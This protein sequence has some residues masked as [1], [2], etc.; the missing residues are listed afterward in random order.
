MRR[1]GRCGRAARY[2][3]A[4]RD[5]PATKPFAK[6]ANQQPCGKVVEPAELLKEGEAGQADDETEDHL[7]PIPHRAGGWVVEHEEGEEEDRLQVWRA[8][9]L[10]NLRPVADDAG[11]R[12]EEE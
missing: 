1:S 8:E 11:Q 7:I 5:P 12:K 9:D 3:R 6:I 4:R 10:R 2:S